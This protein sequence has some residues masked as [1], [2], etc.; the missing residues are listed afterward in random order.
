MS[1]FFR[2]TVDM[3]VSNNV[4]WSIG[5]NTFTVTNGATQ[6]ANCSSLVYYNTHNSIFNLCEPSF[7]HCPIAIAK[8]L[9]S[10]ST[11]VRCC[12]P[13]CP[14]CNGRIQACAPSE[15]SLYRVG[16]ANQSELN[17][18]QWMQTS[19]FVGKG[20][21]TDRDRELEND[22]PENRAPSLYKQRHMHRQSLHILTKNLTENAV[23]N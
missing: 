9:F 10:P 6:A 7:V 2:Y 23:K 18:S 5:K 20:R 8:V 16:V 12:T 22:I 21:K 11:T 1:V 13:A 15:N 3:L 4:Q 14:P 17:T 19:D